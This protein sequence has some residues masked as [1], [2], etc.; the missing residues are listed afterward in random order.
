MIAFG[1]G[2]VA[3]VVVQ[4][5][6]VVRMDV[7]AVKSTVSFLVGFSRP[8]T[9]P[10]PARISNATCIKTLTFDRTK[11]VDFW[12]ESGVRL[13]GLSLLGSYFLVTGAFGTLV[14]LLLLRENRRP[15]KARV[16]SRKRRAG[17]ATT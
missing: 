12:G 16:T 8:K 2:L 5:F 17:S 15:P 4:S 6:V 3:F 14:G 9:A 13:A 1:V 10:C 11:I 7:P